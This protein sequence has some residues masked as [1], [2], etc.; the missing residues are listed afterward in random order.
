MTTVAFPAL[1]LVAVKP[2]SSAEIPT[3]VTLKAP[4]ALAGE[5][6]KLS[7]LGRIRDR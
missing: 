7:T 4:A 5:K 6:Q 1:G 3:A 2:D